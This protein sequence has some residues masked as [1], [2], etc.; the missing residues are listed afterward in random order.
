[1][2]VQKDLWDSKKSISEKFRSLICVKMLHL[3]CIP[4]ETMSEEDKI[5]Q[6]NKI[7]KTSHF[8]NNLRN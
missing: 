1:M 6:K 4:F 8:S 3:H 7:D 5:N 2:P